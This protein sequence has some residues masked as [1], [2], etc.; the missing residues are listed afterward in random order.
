MFT[1]VGIYR[2]DLVE[3]FFEEVESVV[4]HVRGVVLYGRW[5]TGPRAFVSV[6]REAYFCRLSRQL[7]KE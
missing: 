6:S 3:A 7:P 1:K 5:I 4:R 2:G